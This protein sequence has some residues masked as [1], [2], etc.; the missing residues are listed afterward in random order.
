[1]PRSIW[2]SLFSLA[3]IMALAAVAT[4]QSTDRDNPTKLTSQEISGY[5][6]GDNSG[7]L[8][9]YSFVAGPGEVVITLDVKAVGYHTSTGFDIFDQNA[10]MITNERVS[11]IKGGEERRV[12]RFVLSRKSSLI[13]RLTPGGTYGKHESGAFRLRLSGAVDVSGASQPTCLPKQGTL[14]I[15]MKDGSV[16]EI[17]LKQADEI[18]IQP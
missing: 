15:K 7:K 17:D 8:Y 5:V 11:A 9:Y 1:M 4:G 3:F 6:D 10:Q 12:N 18:T 2:K 13:I 14:R 16:K